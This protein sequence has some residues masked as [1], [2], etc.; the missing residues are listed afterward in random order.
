MKSE[1]AKM[2]SKA[3]RLGYINSFL[4]SVLGVD[5]ELAA[6]HWEDGPILTT[7]ALQLIG[8]FFLFFVLQSAA[9]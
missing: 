6:Q 5:K 8:T 3:K 1:Y 9:L 4:L 2:E 7:L